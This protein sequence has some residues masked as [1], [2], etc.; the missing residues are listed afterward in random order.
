MAAW[1]QWFASGGDWRS[2]PWFAV[3]CESNGTDLKKAEILSVGWVPIQPPFVAL[4][5]GQYQVIQQQLNLNQS[6]VVH[7][8]THADIQDGEPLQDVLSQLREATQGAY[9]VA[10]HAAFDKT[11]LMNAMRAQGM[12]WQPAG[13][14][15]TLRAERKI[16]N[17]QN[18]VLSGKSLQ[19]DTCCQRY[20]L[21]N[22]HQHH[23]LADAIACAELF[24]AQQYKQS[25]SSELALNQVLARGQ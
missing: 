11:L 10:H 22:Y 15:D 4:G 6:A 25:G 21:P 5:K 13:W 7:Q 3:D 23:A 19:L 17:R 12:V 24:L 16:L 14:Y 18:A 1:K 20:G 8:L 9:L 2:K